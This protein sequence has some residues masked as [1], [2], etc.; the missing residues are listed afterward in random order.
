MKRIFILLLIFQQ[1]AFSQ[2]NEQEL[3]RRDKLELIN[4]LKDLRTIHDGKLINFLSDADMVVRARATYA[5]GSIQDTSVLHLLT[6]NLADKD[7]SVQNAAVFAIGQTGTMLSPKGKKNLE[8]ELIWKRL[9]YTVVDQWLIEELGKFGSEEALN[10]LMIR[11]GNLFPRVHTNELIMSIARFAIREIYNVEAVR[12]LTTFTKPQSPVNWRAMYALMR[13]SSIPESRKE[14][15]YEIH[16][17]SQLY[18]DPNPLVRMHLATLLGK[19]KDESSSLDPV[20]RM[21]Y[22]DGDWRVRVNAIRALANFELRNNEEAI[23]IF[24][25]AFYDEN[26]HIALTALTEF[27][28]TGLTENNGSNATKETFEWLKRIVQ[29]PERAYKWQYQAQAS[30]TYAKLDKVNAIDLLIKNLDTPPLLQAKIIQALAET[31][32]ID[33]AEHIFRF[34]DNNNP[35]IL[36][37]VLDALNTLC[38]QNIKNSKLIEDTYNV[39]VNFL[40]QRDVAA[41]STAATIMRDSLFLRPAAIDPLLETLNWMRSPDH[42]EAMQ[43]IILTLSKLRDEK[44]IS[45]LKRLLQQPDRSVAITAAEALQNI[46]GKDFSRDVQR[47]MQ[48]TYVDFDFAYLRSLGEK[49]TVRVETIRGDIT[50]ELFPEIAPFTILSFLK[51]AEKGFYRG[52][53]FHRIVPNFVIQGGDPRGDGWGGPGYFLRSEFSDLS[54][55]EGYVGMAS[56]GKDTEGSQ[57]FITHSPQPHLDGRYT[58]FGKVIRGMDKVFQLQN[59]DRIFDVKRE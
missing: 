16:N 26:M 3:K 2:L 48:P 47:H 1:I 15:L 49:P 7:A 57:F 42:T 24:K 11:Y 52:T 56:S 12:Y 23:R 58:I 8:T 36:T 27:G 9:G 29:N 35:L 13:I 19:L 43:E 40:R 38:Q 54:F 20:M 53:T 28:R 10:Q 37:S 34:A 21:A 41:V 50:I 30:I 55:N 25:R 14:I 5:F 32:S 22:Y 33:V 59:D 18:K 39:L 51:L 6:R 44:A 46:T 4:R 31:G 17:I 45:I